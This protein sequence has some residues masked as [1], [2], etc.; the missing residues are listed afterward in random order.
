V[1]KQIGPRFSL[2]EAK[3][4]VGLFLDRALRHFVVPQKMVVPRPWTFGWAHC[5]SGFY[6]LTHVEPTLGR[7]SKK[8]GEIV[9]TQLGCPQAIRRIRQ[10]PRRW[11]N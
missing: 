3:A 8:I 2:D 9:K 1:E 11:I 4:F 10:I 6:Q 5:R 7:I